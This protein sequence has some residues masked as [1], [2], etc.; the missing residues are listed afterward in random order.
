MKR[1]IK[2]LVAGALAS[3]LLLATAGAA[4]AYPAPPWEP[5]HSLSDEGNLTFYDASGNII[6]SGSM[7]TLIPYIATDGTPGAVYDGSATLYGVVA[8]A[9]LTPEQWAAPAPEQMSGT[10]TFPN[11][12]Y[13]PPLNVGPHAV[14]SNEG[15]ANAGNET[16]ATLVSDQ[17]PPA[18]DAG[19][20][21]EDVY[22]LRL[23]TSGSG[24]VDPGF[25]ETDIL[26]NPSAGTWQQIYPATTTTNTLTV[27]PASPQTQGTTLNLTDT[28]V[29]STAT[30]TVQ[31]FAD[32]STS[33]GTAAVSGGVASTTNNTLAAGSHSL[34]AVFTPGDSTSYMP[35]TST[36]VPYTIN[37]VVQ[38][39][40]TTT[41][42][43][44]TGA[45]AAFS[46]VTFTATVS[47]TAAGTVTFAE[48]PTGTVLG[49]ASVNTGTG[50]AVFV[51]SS[52][53]AGPYSVDAAFA[54][55]NP[56]AFGNSTSSAVNFTLA[57]GSF[58]AGFTETQTVVGTI[59]AGT[60]VINTP[61]TASN[62]LNLGTLTLNA[63]A[64]QF[65]ATATF[66]DITITDTR[67]GAFSITAKAQSY[68]MTDGSG[69]T[70]N[71]ENEGLT[72]LVTSYIPGNGINATTDPVTT[73]DNPAANPAVSPSDPGAQG[74]ALFGHTIATVPN[75]PGSFTMNGTFTLNAPSST[76]AGTY[77][78]LV[79]FTV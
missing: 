73:F 55:A 62:P 19:T 13:P 14:V 2:A 16:I 79:V 52:L 3:G 65:S 12:S 58:V 71:A 74:L 36:A 5:D 33:L 23:V 30:G 27:S 60:I 43:V 9:G 56:A 69:G 31:F 7:S 20:A 54:A 8:Q 67:A 34:T 32:G 75:G 47:P 11:A 53:A 49:T 39:S 68:N 48:T 10:E 28:V 40:T 57:Q 63:A 1:H 51:D 6:N 4:F 38:Q 78:G 70:I 42:G 61:Y 64:T 24:G 72:G 29:P 37:A 46:P 45:G 26:V 44:D 77:T 66:T 59:P 25:W 41:L 18:A 17:P 35:S 76:P 22:Q 21:Y 50:Q 15:A